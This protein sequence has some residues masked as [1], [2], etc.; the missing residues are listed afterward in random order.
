MHSDVPRLAPNAN[1]RH[2][3]TVERL[4]GCLDRHD[5]GALRRWTGVIIPTRLRTFSSASPGIGK[6]SSN[7]GGEHGGQ[8]FS[9]PALLG[10]GAPTR[11]KG[12][13]GVCTR[14]KS[15]G[16]GLGRLWDVQCLGL[17]TA[18]RDARG[19]AEGELPSDSLLV[20]DLAAGLTRST[21]S[22]AAG[23]GLPAEISESEQG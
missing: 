23:L 9:S 17:R 12:P 10:T 6:K 21:D 13:D 15:E 18:S 11:H 7:S 22:G 14:P 3:L 2:L 16:G 20:Q 8:S 5:L 4:A 19:S 1:L